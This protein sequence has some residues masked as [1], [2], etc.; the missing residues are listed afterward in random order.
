MAAFLSNLRRSGSAEDLA[1]LQQLVSRLDG[2]RSSL[3]QLV[4]HADRSIGQLQRLGTLGERVNTLERQLA[5]IEHLA[6]R[7]GAAESQLAGLTSTHTRLETQMAESAT[8]IEQARVDVT[9]LTETVAATSR[10]K[11]ELSGFLSLKGP[12]A[13]LRAEMDGLQAQNETFRTDFARLRD[14]HDTTLGAY[15]AAAGRIESF[16]GDWQRITRTVAETETRISGLEQLL[17]DMAPVAESVAQTKRQLVSARAMADQL[18]QKVALLEQ[19]RDEVDRATA[20]LDHLTTLVQRA[21]AGV[22]RQ[23]EAVRMV[24]ALRTELEVLQETQIALNERGRSVHDRLERIESGQMAAERALSGLREGLDQS[25]ERLAVDGRSVEGMGQ[26]VGDLRR[27]LAEWEARF[28]TLAAGAEAITSAAAKADT[29]TA[30]VADIGGE[31]E[32]V[33]EFGQRVRAGLADLERL[34]TSIGGLTERTCRVEESRSLLDRTVRDLA[35]LSATGE[36]LHESLETLRAARQELSESRGQM[37]QTR[38]WLGET[39]RSVAALRTDVAGLDRMRATV[40]SLRQ[41]LEQLNTAMNL[42]ESRK[43][44]VDDVQRRLTESAAM[45]SSIEA[46]ARGLAERLEAAED[47]LGTLV[48]RLDEVGR[49]GN[50]LV[51]LGADLREMEERLRAVQGTVTGVQE[52]AS[53][54]EALAGR[55]QDLSREIEQRQKALAKATEHLDRA[56]TLRQE[57]AV[58]AQTLADRAREVDASLVNADNRLATC[59]SL[60]RELESRIGML[61]TAQ[62]R[63]TAFEAKLAEWRGAEQQL[64][65]AMDQANARQATITSLQAEIR[66][67]FDMAERTQA[68]ARA[69]TT[70]QPQMA[71]AR[72]DLDELLARLGDTDGIMHTLEERRRQ[73]DRTEERLAHADLLATDVRSSLEI[74]L[75]QKAQVDHFLEMATALQLETRRVESLMEALRDERRMSDRVQASLV[76]LRRQSDGG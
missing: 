42:V 9:L 50:Q 21:D 53:G 68:D 47:H 31:L 14:Q 18:A 34:E 51:S 24:A 52:R 36:A 71:R 46:R 56:A 40:D 65:Q 72:A 30:Q 10:L 20:K 6:A 43:G 16:D 32:R 58:A 3:E 39:D 11:D 15:K 22:E 19:Q 5:G 35:G 73:L 27:N 37:Q 41:E 2:Q 7:L 38:T 63:I 61:T 33:A 70:A 29:L 26:R 75:A 49:A 76:G 28:A 60:S 57:A 25:A 69:L 55:M 8:G 45:G 74:L 67:L 12:F 13:Q 48:P 1:E 54:L 66:A 64:S 4:Q 17:A 62:E 44:M 23:A 59:E